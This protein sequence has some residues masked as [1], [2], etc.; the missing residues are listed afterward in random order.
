MRSRGSDGV[1]W[2]RSAAGVYQVLREQYH[3]NDIDDSQFMCASIEFAV[4]PD[5]VKYLSHIYSLLSAILSADSTL[6]VHRCTRDIPQ[7]F[8]KRI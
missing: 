5:N 1:H 6:P 7:A 4:H 3:G 8:V 2:V